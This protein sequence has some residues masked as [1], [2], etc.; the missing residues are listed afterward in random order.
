MITADGSDDKFIQPE[1]LPNYAVAPPSP[2]DP[3]SGAPVTGNDVAT[4]SEKN[5]TKEADD[6]EREEED[7]EVIQQQG[8]GERN[9]FGILI[10]DLL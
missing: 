1:G 6:F 8:E 2:L 7:F 10:S 5:E 3:S 9:I 4:E